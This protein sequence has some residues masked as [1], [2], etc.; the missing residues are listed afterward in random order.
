[1]A[2]PVVQLSDFDPEPLIEYAITERDL[3]SVY[4]YLHAM[5]AH[6]NGGTW[7]EICEGRYYGASALLHE[8]VE[9]RILLR[10]DPYLLTRNEDEIKVF[11]R[12]AQNLDAHLRGLEAEY[13]YLQSVIHELF[14]E[15]ID[16][17]ALVRVNTQRFDDWDDLFETNLRFHDPSSEEIA[18]AQQWLV[19]LRN[20]GVIA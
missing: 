10:R 11:A 3:T 6:L 13:R 9:L 15:W 12:Q 16:I 5:Q 14:G 1:M 19:R 18:A 4:Q 7:E 2:R 17:G 8:V 20:R